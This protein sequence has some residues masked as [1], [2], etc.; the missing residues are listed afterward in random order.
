MRI[1]EAPLTPLFPGPMAQ[2]TGAIYL[3]LSDLHVPG[4]RPGPWVVWARATWEPYCDLSQLG[5]PDWWKYHTS[6]CAEW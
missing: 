5:T 3:A 6:A 2:E 4:D 1:A